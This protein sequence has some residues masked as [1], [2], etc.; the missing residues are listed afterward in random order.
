MQAAKWHLLA[1]AGGKDDS[2]LDTFLD[3]LTPE[4][5]QNALAAAQRFPAD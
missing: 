2:W 5:K 1:R 4:Q 3:G